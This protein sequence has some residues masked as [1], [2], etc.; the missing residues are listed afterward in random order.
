MVSLVPPP[1][2][3]PQK[4]KKKKRKKKKEKEKKA[5]L[6]DLIAATGL[7]IL[8]KLDSNCQFFSPCDIEVRW[9]ILENNKGHLLYYAKL[10]ASFQIHR[11]IQIGF[12]VWKHSI[13]AK[14][15]D[16]LS[17]V[18]LK[19]DRCYWKTIG[20]LFYATSSFL[21]H[22]VAISEFKLEFQSGN[23]QFGSK[24]TNFI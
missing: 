24:S 22:F 7:V 21:H 10:C 4:K 5:N 3:P 20:H 8:L 15:A 6:G 12:A 13:R 18:T 9:M 23:T 14:I 16:F 19:F 2:P 17:R 1:P 11:W